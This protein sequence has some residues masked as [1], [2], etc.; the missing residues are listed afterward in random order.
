MSSFDYL[1]LDIESYLI[2][3]CTVCKTLVEL[4][5]PDDKGVYVEALDIKKGKSYL[6]DIIDG[7][8]EELDAS[9]VLIVVGDSNNF[10]KK[11]NPNYKHNRKSKPVI[12]DM[13]FDWLTKKYKVIFLEG[14]EADDTCRVIYEDDENFKGRKV[15]VSVD[16]DFYSVPCTF[17]RDN[18]ADRRVVTVSKEDARVNLFVQVLMGDKTDG[19]E[20]CRN[21][22]PVTARSLVNTE[23]TIDDMIK[24]YKDNDM[25]VEDFERN[26]F[27][28]NIVGLR[29]YSLI[30]NSIEF[31]TVDGEY[32][33]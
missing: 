3:A 23:T 4:S 19:Y 12:Y 30:T 18:P 27:M 7:F 1:I 14:L 31:K 22:G 13:L 33:I 26:L 9:N 10:R 16:K 29:N 25:E 15:I 20:G 6:N 17:Y 8:K 32:I 2:K 11:I 5:N 28:A 24:I 21:I